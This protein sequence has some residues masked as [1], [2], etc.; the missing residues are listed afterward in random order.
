M[1]YLPLPAAF[2][3]QSGT[4][5]DVG[6][7]EGDAV[8]WF[9]PSSRLYRPSARL[10]EFVT[11]TVE[12]MEGV[13]GVESATFVNQPPL[14]S[15]LV[16]RSATVVLP[17]GDPEAAPQVR[18]KWVTPGY[19]ETLGIPILAGRS[20]RAGDTR[21]SPPV[22]VVNEP[23]V[24]DVLGSGSPLGRSV[25][26]VL[27]PWLPPRDW[28]IVGVVPPVLQ[29]GPHE[30]DEPVVYMTLA[31]LPDRWTP[32]QIGFARRVTFLA[33]FRGDAAE[34]LQAL[35]EA[36]WAGEPELAIREEATLDELYQRVTAQPRF[37]LLLLG[38]FAGI[39]LLL[40]ALGIL[41]SLGQHVRQ[42]TR[43]LGVRQALGAGARDLFRR[44]VL[45]GA[46]LGLAGV[47]LGAGIGWAISRLLSTRVV[48]AAAWSPLLQGSVA[49]GLV[50]IAAFAAVPAALRA[51]RVDPME[52]LRSD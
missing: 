30:P 27:P 9:E 38:S 25:P 16:W 15:S 24:R 42:R 26:L 44:T 45:D 33:R 23:F 14:W 28:T 3:E 4:M 51:I 32:D 10:H 41:A 1:L 29:Y 6:G 34:T 22:L 49:L 50:A 8:R 7:P 18:V 47:V 35:R 12:R 31:Q 20:L 40:S 11:G 48:G 43:E 46:A 19:F 13:A 37:F 52:A 5:A 39:S 21:E 36:V 2:H 17:G